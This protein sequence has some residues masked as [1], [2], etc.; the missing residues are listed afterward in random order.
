MNRTLTLDP[1]WRTA[2]IAL[3]ALLLAGAAFAAPDAARVRFEREQA[4]CMSG[5]SQQD[6]ASCLKEARNA[7]AEARRGRLDNGQ[8]AAHDANATQRCERLPADQKA[9][10]VA[11]MR[12]EGTVSGS[13][14]GGGLYREKV[15]VEVGAPGAAATSGAAAGLPSSGTVPADTATSL[16]ATTPP[17]TGRLGTTTPPVVTPPVAPTR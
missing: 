2:A 14:E 1:S 4:R 11:R 9:D 15:T 5:Q 17:D 8:Q 12:G 13:V 10:C 6:R 7:Y 3:G 16:P